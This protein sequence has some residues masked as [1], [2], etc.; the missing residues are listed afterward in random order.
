MVVDAGEL[1]P[2]MGI[3]MLAGTTLFSI[4]GAYALG[5]GR[6]RDDRV[7]AATDPELADRV[8]RVERLMETMAVEIERIGES[9][10]FL[11]KVLS[12]K[13]LPGA[14]PPRSPERVITPH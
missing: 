5:R 13:Q 14:E 3:A 7:V 12:A 2:I 11:V 1:I 9:Q 4:A 8:E 6:R 10:R